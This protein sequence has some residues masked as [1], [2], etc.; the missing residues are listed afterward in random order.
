MRNPKQ[1]IEIKLRMNIKFYLKNHPFLNTFKELIAN[2][3][4]PM[5]QN[6]LLTLIMCL[7]L[8]SSLW[9]QDARK[10]VADFDK[11]GSVKAA[12][13]FFDYLDQEQFTDERIQFATNTPTDSLRKEVWYWAGEW[14]NDTQEYGLARQYALRALPLYLSLIHI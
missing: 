7:L 6:Y 10:L 12:N 1:P 3:A 9:A 2:F 11:K 5:K 4:P 14:F 8:S 13:R